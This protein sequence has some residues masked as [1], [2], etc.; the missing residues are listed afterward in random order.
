[1]PRRPVFT[2]ADI[3]RALRAAAAICGEPL[4]HGR[5]DAV[6][7]EVGGPTAT[8][9]IQRFGTWSAACAAAGVRSAAPQRAYRQL[10]D[11]DRVAAAVREYLADEPA[12]T[13]AG[14]AQ[15]ARAA[16]GRPSGTTVRN[17]LGNWNAAKAAAF[18]GS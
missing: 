12:G 2:E 17:V 3:L 4:S 11:A 16:D 10:W 14:Y 15:W 1:M 8:R 7:R 6:A 9:I 5:Y 18:D 13:Y